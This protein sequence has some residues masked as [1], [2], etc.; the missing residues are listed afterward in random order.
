VL[1]VLSVCRNAF[2]MDELA[3][4]HWL[5]KVTL[6]PIIYVSCITISAP[7]VYCVKK[8]FS[9]LLEFRPLAIKCVLLVFHS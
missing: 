8:K 5:E 9:Q 4:P 1:D 2:T 6:L 7:E 3:Y